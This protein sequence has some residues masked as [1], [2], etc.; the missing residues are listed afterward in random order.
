MSTAAEYVLEAFEKLSPEERR[1]VAS[2][3]LRHVGEL[4]FPPLD[5]E[6]MA[7]LADETFQEYDAREAARHEN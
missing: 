7:Q 6:A 5:D 2:V 3:I 1:E 4:E